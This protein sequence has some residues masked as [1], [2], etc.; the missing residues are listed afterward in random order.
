MVKVIFVY[1]T[2]RISKMKIPTWAVVMM[3]VS[4]AVGTVLLAMELMHRTKTGTL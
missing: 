1:I 4:S 2:K 3:L